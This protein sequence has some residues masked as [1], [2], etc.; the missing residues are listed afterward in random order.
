MESVATRLKSRANSSTPRGSTSPLLH[1]AG[2]YAL[3]HARVAKRI[4]LF[5][6]RERHAIQLGVGVDGIIQQTGFLWRR[7]FDVAAQREHDAVHV[8]PAEE[9][10]D[11]L[12]V[13]PRFG[14]VNGNPPNAADVKFRPAVITRNRALCLIEGERETNFES[15]RNSLSARHADK[16]RMKIGAVA[17]LRITGPHSVAAAPVSAVMVVMHRG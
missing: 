11:F 1:S 5:Q 14:G 10:I 7:Q 17:V 9:I 12:F 8:Q 13:L 6:A 3:C 16:K 4:V 2:R 15:R